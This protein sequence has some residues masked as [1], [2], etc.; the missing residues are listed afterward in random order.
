MR[1]LLQ[2]PLDLL[3]LA[4]AHDML[5]ILQRLHKALLLIVGLL[6]LLQLL[7]ASLLL[8][9]LLLELSI[10]CRKCG[11]RLVARKPTTHI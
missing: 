9:P 11:G 1:L 6:L 5:L 8:L 2:Q 4:A 7:H 10:H 3:L